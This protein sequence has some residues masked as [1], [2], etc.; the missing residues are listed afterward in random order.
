MLQVPNTPVRLIFFISLLKDFCVAFFSSA[1]AHE[2][3][4]DFA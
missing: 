4:S 3:P 1:A 2:N